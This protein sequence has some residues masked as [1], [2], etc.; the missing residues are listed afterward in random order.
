MSNLFIENLKSLNRKERYHLLKLVTGEKLQV[1]E[2][3]GDKLKEELKLSY[4]PPENAFVAIDYHI[5]WLAACVEV[6]R[7]P[8]EQHYN[9]TRLIKRTQITW[10][11]KQPPAEHIYWID[12]NQE[13]VDLLVAY[14]DPK[15][16]SRTH[17]I[18][19]EAKAD[20]SWTRKQLIS[21]IERLRHIFSEKIIDELGLSLHFVLIGPVGPRG[22]SSITSL[23]KSEHEAHHFPDWYKIEAGKDDNVAFIEIE[24]L[25]DHRKP[26]RFNLQGNNKK[27]DYWK[28]V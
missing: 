11:D 10:K 25:R 14:P 2:D 4:R 16:K 21:K 27:F 7:H 18:L 9:N 15:A 19:G 5:D 28:L 22:E 8:D 17:L 20:T 6:T 1:G 24:S 12:G 13:D 3:F 23:H 26:E